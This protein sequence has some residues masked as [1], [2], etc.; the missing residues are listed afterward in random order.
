MAFKTEYEFTLPLGYVDK[1][2]NV[3]RR[4]T[5]RLA[6]AKDEILPL[7]DARVQKNR[8]YLIVIL[9]SRVISRMEGISSVTPNIIEDLFAEDLRYLQTL[10]QQ[11]NR[12]GSPNVDVRCPHCKGDFQLDLGG[13][14]SGE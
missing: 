6:T 13:I 14:A 11:I 5:M 7:Q 9:L 10:Y 12:T 3:H 8:S 4:G 2:G 1:D